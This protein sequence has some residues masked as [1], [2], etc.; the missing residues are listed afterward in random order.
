VVVVLEL[1]VVE[2]VVLEVVVA[3]GPDDTISRTVLP[4]DSSVFA[5]G[6]VEITVPAGT[7]V[8]DCSLWV[9]RNPS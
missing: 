8:D 4:F 6:S 7:E 3:G 1:V 2:V 5:G 9:T